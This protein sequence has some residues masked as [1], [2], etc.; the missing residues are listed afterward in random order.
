VLNNM[1]DFQAPSDHRL[2][3]NPQTGEP[4]SGGDGGGSGNNH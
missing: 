4:R 3:L 2:F 1:F